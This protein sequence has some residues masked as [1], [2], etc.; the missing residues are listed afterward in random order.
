MEN[1]GIS[2]LQISKQRKRGRYS[3]VVAG[4]VL[5]LLLAAC[6]SSSTASSSSSSTTA[7]SGSSTSASSAA[8]V[9]KATAEL[10]KYSSAQPLTPPG[11]AFN[12][13]KASGKLVWLIEQQSANPAVAAVAKNAETALAHENVRV[14]TCDAHGVSVNI[15]NCIQQ[16]LSQHPA[17]IIVDGGDPQ[18]Y[19]SGIQAANSAHVPIISGLDVPIPTSSDASQIDP[20]LTGIAANAGPP[21][22]LSGTLAADYVVKNSNA[23]AHVLFLSS[24]GIL[25]S[26]FEE[27]NFASTLKSLCPKC[28]LI[29]KPVVITNWA[30]DLGPTVSSQLQLHPNIN[31]VVPVFDP[32]AAYTD[33]AI[34]QAGKASSVKVVTVNG[35]L[36][37]MTNLS[38]K[39]V[40]VC[41]VGQNLAELGFLAAD[42]TLRYISGVPSSDLVKEVQ[43]GVRVFSASNIGSVSLTPTAFNSGE[44]YTGSASAM[45]DMFYKLWSGS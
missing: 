4:G 42:E 37:Q 29:V 32:M 38:Q 2:E 45:T 8:G 6:G 43:P 22:P 9:A 25:G 16:G 14:L 19:T 24:P 31:Y 3:A 11:P 30:S 23:N 28:T 39:Q 18:S 12:A 17:A 26:N 20:H 7:A 13:S 1:L 27:Q 10:A 40:I 5:A 36:Q 34:I 35:S 33:P 41:D 21:D 44:W 15:G